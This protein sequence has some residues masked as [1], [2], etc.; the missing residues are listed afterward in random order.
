MLCEFSFPDCDRGIN[1]IT[2]EYGLSTSTVLYGLQIAVDCK[3]E[4]T[5]QPREGLC[6]KTA[7]LR[8]A[9]KSGVLTLPGDCCK[10]KSPNLRLNYRAAESVSVLVFLVWVLFPW[11][12]TMTTATLI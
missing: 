1:R 11:R 8:V 7:G 2:G 12:D 5:P 10:W 9:C 3:N 6:L 4:W